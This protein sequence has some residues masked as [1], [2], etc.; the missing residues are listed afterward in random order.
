MHAHRLWLAVL[1]LLWCSACQPEPQPTVIRIGF[2]A[3]FE[4]RYR[5]I[6]TDVITA[7]RIATRDW[8]AWA[9]PTLPRFVITAYDDLGDPE[10]AVEQAR[11]IAADPAVA[12]VIGHWRDETTQAALPLYEDLPVVT[13][14]PLEM[15]HALNLS[16]A[17]GDLLSAQGAWALEHNPA[18][19]V[20]DRGSAAGNLDGL[21]EAADLLPGSTIV[22]GPGAGL[23]QFRALAATETLP[24][25]SV[26]FVT[27]G[28][29]PADRAGWD[30]DFA[31][32]FEEAFR[33][34]SLGAA[35]GLMAAAAYEATWVAMHT[36]L[37]AEGIDMPETIVPVALP[38]FDRSGRWHMAPIYLYTW[39]NGQPHLVE[40]YR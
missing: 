4:G 20:G 35:P 15:D 17:Q 12:V 37:E 31:R 29:L 8:A 19:V 10:L 18:V 39:Q 38:S 22:M 7:A 26:V 6:G 28:A 9:D 25:E 36:A 13:F 33:E 34:A 23:A 2:V 14:S 21:R 3:P 32:R 5:E 40:Q 16:A 11:K 24:T 27:S 1:A 30:T